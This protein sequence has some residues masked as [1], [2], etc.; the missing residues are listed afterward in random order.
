MKK[1]LF[2]AIA[3]IAFCIPSWGQISKRAA[4]QN[5]TLAEARF[6]LRSIVKYVIDGEDYF[7]LSM[8]TDNRFDQPMCL[9]LGKT[10]E[11]AVKTMDDLIAMY[12]DTQEGVIV[13]ITDGM[14]VTFTCCY[15]KLAGERNLMFSADGFAG[16]AWVAL[17]E[18][19]NL[20]KKMQR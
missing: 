4:V 18:M 11:Q 3:A 10:M 12:D 1:Y 13:E 17:R 15:Q 16:E 8:A 9:L 19:K 14:G 6:G 2:L 7:I 5:E 20:Q